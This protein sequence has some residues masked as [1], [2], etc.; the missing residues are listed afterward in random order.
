MRSIRE[1]QYVRDRDRARR[2]A[3]RFARDRAE[4]L[5]HALDLLRV[6]LDEQRHLRAEEHE[7]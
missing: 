4:Q 1:D 2:N 6:R 3:T 7:Q 5:G